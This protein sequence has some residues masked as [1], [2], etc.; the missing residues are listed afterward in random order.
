MEDER[1]KRARE[2][3]FGSVTDG[4]VHTHTRLR[5]KMSVDLSLGASKVGKNKESKQA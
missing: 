2:K 4:P 1:E 5:L 3:S